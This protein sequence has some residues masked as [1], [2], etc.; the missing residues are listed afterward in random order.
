MT[1]R[2]E[3]FKKPYDKPTRSAEERFKAD[4]K[5]VCRRMRAREIDDDDRLVDIEEYI[6]EKYEPRD[7]IV[8]PS[9]AHRIASNYRGGI[10]L[11]DKSGEIRK[12]V[13]VLKDGRV[14]LD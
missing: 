1:D 10:I 4:L 8:I 2:D 6:R 7:F 14:C 9:W 3:R 5:E 12:E 13:I 11:I